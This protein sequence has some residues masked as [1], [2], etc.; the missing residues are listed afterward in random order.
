MKGNIL[1]IQ[2]EFE[3]EKWQVHAADV[4][5]QCLLSGGKISVWTLHY[6]GCFYNIPYSWRKGIYNT[7]VKHGMLKKTSFT[8]NYD[9]VFFEVTQKAIDLWKKDV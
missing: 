8:R 4:V 6:K 2:N 1:A 5:R 3:G 7:C 9:N